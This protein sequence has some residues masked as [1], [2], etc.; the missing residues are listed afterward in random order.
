MLAPTILSVVTFQ[1]TAPT[2]GIVLAVDP[3]IRCLVYGFTITDGTGG[4]LKMFFGSDSP[5]KAIISM[6]AV[7]NGGAALTFARGSAVM[8]GPGEDVLVTAPG[9][10]DVTLYYTLQPAAYG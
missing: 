7:A 10:C 6:G 5:E 8:G 1:A 3:G 4:V 2:A 9:I